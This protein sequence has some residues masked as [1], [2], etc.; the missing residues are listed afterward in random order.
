MTDDFGAFKTQPVTITINGINDAPVAD[1]EVNSTPEDTTLT[2]AAAS[3]VLIGD[4]D[5]DGDPLT[6]TQFTVAGVAGTFTA[7]NTAA[8]PGVG[9]LTINATAATRLC[10]RRTTTGRYRLRP[11]RCR[12]VRSPIP[13]P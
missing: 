3:G 6:V 7:G 5:P 11:I 10:R 9:S 8:I 4:V 2:V 1:N 12:T 13:E